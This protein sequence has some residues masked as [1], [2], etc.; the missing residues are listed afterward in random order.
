MQAVQA[1]SEGDAGVGDAVVGRAQASA[2][3]E[4]DRY[5]DLPV[6]DRVDADTWPGWVPVLGGPVGV[7]DAGSRCGERFADSRETS[8]GQTGAGMF[9]RRGV[10][11]CSF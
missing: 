3:R 10:G 7:A 4:G 6:G 1:W 2:A 5:G 8:P 9:D 11:S